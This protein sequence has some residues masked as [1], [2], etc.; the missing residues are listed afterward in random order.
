MVQNDIR[1][2][3]VMLV[4]QKAEA[5]L[6]AARAED[7]KATDAA[8]EMSVADVLKY[9]GAKDVSF[10]VSVAKGTKSNNQ[11]QEF[12]FLTAKALTE[13][14]F[15][16]LPIEFSQRHQA[17]VS[18]VEAL[19]SVMGSTV[20]NARCIVGI[21][22]EEVGKDDDGKPVEQKRIGMKWEAIHFAE[23]EP[24]VWFKFSGPVRKYNE[25]TK[26]FDVPVIAD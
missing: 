15:S 20:D 8:I 16:T 12:T 23:D 1:L 7:A 24:N 3:F 10:S 26:T 19:K 18:E 21:H 22:V 5:A 25:A 14:G 11:G 4:N 9:L 6:I 17:K 2:N 13:D